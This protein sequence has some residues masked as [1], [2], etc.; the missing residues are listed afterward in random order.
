MYGAW[1]SKCYNS[2]TGSEALG[3]GAYGVTVCEG[4]L[5]AEN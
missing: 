4:S 1:H 3:V 2:G 5:S